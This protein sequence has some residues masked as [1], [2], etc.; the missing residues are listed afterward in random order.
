MR[1]ETV[2]ENQVDQT[3]KKFTFWKYWEIQNQTIKARPGSLPYMWKA[4]QLRQ[5]LKT[6]WEKT[7]QC[8]KVRESPAFFKLIQAWSIGEGEGGWSCS[9]TKSFWH[10]REHHQRVNVQ[11]S[12]ALCLHCDSDSRWVSLAR[13]DFSCD[14]CG[15]N[16]TNR[17]LLQSHIKRQH[18]VIYY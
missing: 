18:E 10:P 16:F 11:T 4:V 5:E 17:A 9:C 1:S 8:L 2:Q 13:G 15:K 14:G 3:H 12:D 7:A 6:P